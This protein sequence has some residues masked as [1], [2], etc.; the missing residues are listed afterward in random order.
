MTLQI[1]AIIW[2]LLIVI[3]MFEAYFSVPK[4]KE[5]DKYKNKKK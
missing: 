2:V 4:D 1:F 5:L 3:C